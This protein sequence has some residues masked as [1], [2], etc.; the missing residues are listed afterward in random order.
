MSRLAGAL[1][2]LRGIEIEAPAVWIGVACAALLL[3]ALSL[4]RG[5]PAL[6]WPALDEAR[7]AGARRF[8][9]LR[10]L[11][12]LLRAGALVALAAV[13]ARPGAAP[14]GSGTRVRGLDLVLVLD[15]S[16]S[17]RALDAQVA[18][19]WRTRLD[20]ARE[21]VGRFALHRVAEGDRVGLVVFGDTAFTLC[22]LASDGALV[23]AALGRVTAGMA[24]DATALGDA[25]A[26]AVKRVAPG[27]LA[28]EGAGSDSAAEADRPKAGRLVV[29]LTDGRANAG[30]VPVD[31]A[32]ALAAATRTRV[33]T[34][35]IGGQGEV[36]VQAPSGR[37]ELRLERHDLDTATL[38]AVAEL[39]GGRFFQARTS[40]DLA[41]VYAAID[42]LERVERPAPPRVTR[43]PR[44]EPFLAGAG[45]LL[46]AEI[47]ATRIL[48]RRLP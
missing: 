15:T 17:M 46:A 42:A 38:G 40:G 14:D 22:P 3:L 5:P 26:L 7:A 29:L 39:S 4:R 1:G 8:D 41:D 11:A 37:R 25:L 31:V 23:A 18:G 43:E 16:A 9:P 36:A 44:P 47:L 35:G 6:P 45:L 34:V 33:H 12:F 24:G 30:S 20:L 10:A 2:W 32:A 13:L 21:V 19:V 28:A 48:G 27:S